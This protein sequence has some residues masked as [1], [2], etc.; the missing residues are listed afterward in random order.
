MPEAANFTESFDRYYR[1]NYVKVYRLAYGLANRNSSV[2]ERDNDA[3]D[4][5]QEA[6]LRAYRSFRTFRKES[7]FFTWICRITMN[8]ANDYMRQRSKL[9]IYETLEELGCSEEELMDPNPANDPETRLLS[10][11]VMRVCMYGFTECLPL[12]QKKAF[13][14]VVGFELPYTLVAEILECSVGSLKTMLHRAKGSLARYMESRCSLVRK[15]NPCR[16]EQW[17]EACLSHNK[18]TKDCITS[19]TATI[20]V[21]DKVKIYMRD[22]RDIY[23]NVYGARSDEEMAEVLKEGFEKKRWATFT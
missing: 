23:H 9:R 7:S 2:A 16:C 5:T 15:S 12:K 1:D 19:P 10:N 18:I 14:L 11:E 21:P 17:V 20:M 6:F 4:I 22:L 3:E 13:L 8:V